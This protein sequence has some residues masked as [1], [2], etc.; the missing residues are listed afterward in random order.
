MGRGKWVASHSSEKGGMH[1]QGVVHRVSGGAMRAYGVVHA[2]MWCDAR[3]HVVWCGVPPSVALCV[4]M[5][6]VWGATCDGVAWCGCYGASMYMVGW[7]G[8]RACVLVRASITLALFFLP[9]PPFAL[10]SS[11]TTATATTATAPT[12]TH[13]LLLP[14]LPDLGLRTPPLIHFIGHEPDVL[15]SL[16]QNSPHMYINVEDYLF[17]NTNNTPNQVSGVRGS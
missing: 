8:V 14:R 16:S 2:R 9:Y 10:P 13:S 1:A 3:A 7:G 12:L 17:Y 6:V 5:P 11:P 4:C 15:L